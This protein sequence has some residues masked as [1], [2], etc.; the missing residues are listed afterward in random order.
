MQFWVNQSFNGIS[1]AALLFLVGGGLTLIFGV[2]RVVNIA[3]GSFYLVGGYLGVV[4]S[5]RTG[6]FYVALLGAAGVVALGG[7]ALER[8]FLRAVEGDD[9]RQMLLTMGIALFFQDLCLLIWGGDPFNLRGPVYF[10]HSLHLGPFS[11]PIL[12]LFMIGAAGVLFVIL[13]WFQERTRAGA[14]VRA[15]VDNAEMT[16]ALGINVPVLRMGVFG[17]GAL[18][19]GLGGVIGSAFMGIYPG[20]DFEILPYA[21]VVVIVGGM[22]SLG[23]ALAA[24]VILGLL[25]NFGKALFPEISYFT[26]FAPMGIVLALRPSGL[27]GRA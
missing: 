11:F 10:A 15:A 16:E 8:V 14:M 3:H 24:A 1:Y 25:D 22:G 7:A 12:R 4:L 20:L 6:N 2:M 21:F 13:W 9:L 18:L 19:A 23:G 5:A 26:L 17:L 27:F